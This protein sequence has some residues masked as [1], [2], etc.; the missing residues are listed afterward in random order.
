MKINIFNKQKKFEE[1]VRGSQ[2]DIQVRRIGYYA[3]AAAGNA[4]TDGAAAADGAC[5]AC[6]A[7]QADTDR[8]DG[9]PR[10]RGYVAYRFESASETNYTQ[11][12]LSVEELIYDSGEVLRALLGALKMQ[13]DLAQTVILRTGEENFHHL[14]S[15]P[16]D[17]SKNYIDFGFLQTNVSAVGTMFKIV[18][19]EAFIQ[20]TD[21]R[22]FPSGSLTAEFC[23]FDEMR[24]AEQK[25]RIR[26]AEGRWSF[27]EAGRTAGEDE[28]NAAGAKDL[29]TVEEP[30]DITVH[31]SQGEFASLL[32]GSADLGALVRLGAVSV[33][34]G[35][36]GGGRN[37][38]QADAVRMLTQMLYCSQKPWLN[39]DY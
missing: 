18:E 1:E 4:C 19:P 24:Y 8:R 14:L 31:C 7:A 34:A 20:K 12:R 2:D 35:N 6:E 5:R 22:V 32:M 3:D 10:L 17:I 37:A 21:Y 33:H 30:V 26:F 28:K 38:E 25:I 29:E 16:Q 27:T 13:E 9:Q 36:A 15:D 39:A 23:Y 11:N